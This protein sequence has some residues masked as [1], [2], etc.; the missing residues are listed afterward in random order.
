MAEL[1]EKPVNSSE[2]Q[3][4]RGRKPGKAS[5][6]KPKGREFRE[7]KDQRKRMGTR[8]WIWHQGVTVP[9]K[10]MVSLKCRVRRVKERR[11]KGN[12]SQTAGVLSPRQAGETG[13]EGEKA[14]GCWNGRR[15]GRRFFSVPRL[16]NQGEGADGRGGGEGAER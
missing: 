3:P 14:G 2:K 1:A 6:Q 4:G 13:K 8:Y 12:R 9:F 16:E 7:G 10:G 5:S 11:P 15:S